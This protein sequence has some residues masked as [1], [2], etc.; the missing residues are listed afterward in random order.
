MDNNSAA[1]RV[2]IADDEKP[3]AKALSLKLSKSGYQV[4]S[5][6]NGALAIEELNNNHYDILLLDLIMP[7]VDG[8]EVLRH[9]DQNGLLD[10]LKVFI[11][12]NLGQSEDIEKTKNY[13]IAEHIVKSNSTLAEIVN[14]I[15]SYLKK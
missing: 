3:L 14:M 4:N 15:D 7:E 8:F 11:L 9:L 10:Q 12:S 1:K 2:L 5:V 13:K 6:E